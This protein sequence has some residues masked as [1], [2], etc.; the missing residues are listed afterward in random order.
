[1]LTLDKTEETGPCLLLGSERFGDTDRGV[2][3]RGVDDESEWE[4]R[5]LF[6]R[7]SRSQRLQLE[8][9]CGMAVITLRKG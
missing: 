2:G 3:G 5:E 7:V 6:V 9:E 8:G 1:M 4:R